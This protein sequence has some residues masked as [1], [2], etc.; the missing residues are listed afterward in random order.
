MSRRPQRFCSVP[1]SDCVGYSYVAS[2]GH[3]GPLAV[4][5]ADNL[6]DAFLTGVKLAADCSAERIS[7]FL[8]GTCGSA[9]SLAVDHGMR[10]TFPM[11]LMATPGYGGWTQ[12][13]PRNPG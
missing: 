8:P 11:L 3:I 2:N 9:L 10:I 1:G 12:Y 13:L 5:R 4:M 7:A 6:G